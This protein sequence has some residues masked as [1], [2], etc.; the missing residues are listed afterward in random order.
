MVTTSTTTNNKQKSAAAL[1][2]LAWGGLEV[3]TLPLPS[4]LQTVVSSHLIAQVV[5][6]TTRRARVFRA[7]TKDRAEVRGGGRKPWKQKGTGRSRHGSSRSPLWVGG[8]TTFGPRTRPTTVGAIP[9]QL[10]RQALAGALAAL[11]ADKQLAITRFPAELPGKTKAVVT[12][13]PVDIHGLLMI[14]APD[15][16][17]VLQRAARNIAG[18]RIAASDRV[19]ASDVVRARTVWLDEE[20]LPMITKRCTAHI[21]ESASSLT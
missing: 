8:G 18:V 14:V 5:R 9:K 3:G 16:L 20:A 7:H 4:Y 11:A 10:R 2:I 21:Q 6:T 15:R 12:A 13:L 1:P 19:T 17:G